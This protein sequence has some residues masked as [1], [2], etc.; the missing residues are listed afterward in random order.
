MSEKESLAVV[1]SLVNIVTGDFSN[2][3]VPR[4]DG[5]LPTFTHLVAGVFL[6]HPESHR[7]L[8]QRRSMSRPSYP[9]FFTDSASGYVH[10]DPDLDLEAIKA[11][12]CR[13]L[14][15]E[16][17]VV[18]S[19]ADLRFWTIYY[20]AKTN[21]IKFV[22]T[23]TVAT[24]AFTIDE[25]EVCREGSGWYTVA[26][27]DQI[28][29]SE[30]FISSSAG[31]WEALVALEPTYA[32]LYNGLE[33]WQEFWTQFDDLARFRSWMAE[34]SPSEPVPVYLG[35]FQPLHRGH[36]ECFRQIRER[37]GTIVVAVGS[38]QY[39]GIPGN[40]LSFAERR[41]MISAVLEGEGLEF[42]RAF[43]IPLPD[44]HQEKLW[45]QNV[46][47]LL[48]DGVIIHSNNDWV[49]DLAAAEGYPVADKFEFDV[50]HLNGT[51]V[52]ALLHDGE[53]WASLVPGSCLAY[54]EEHGL[55]EKIRTA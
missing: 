46:H 16:M 51:R 52:R 27:L 50:E 31:L 44:I 22:F 36:L 8:V 3:A 28:L 9:G 24:D 53:D 34:S 13:E 54:L 25:D 38:A 2:E 39:G 48:G 20:S 23:G 37:S 21:E 12:M 32:Q 18:T 15:E 49:R 35:R 26:D 17:G 41:G 19:T 7:F 10:A 45:M 1:S 29:H 42:D 33:P 40:P 43:I 11:E 4:E 30:P 6:Y 14:E 55:V 5:D 47:L